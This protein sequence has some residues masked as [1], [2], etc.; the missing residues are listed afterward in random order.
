MELERV[1]L[2]VAYCL[3]EISYC[4]GM[5]FIASVTI[6]VMESEESGFFVFMHLLLNKDVK[7]LFLPV[8]LH[9]NLHRAYQSFT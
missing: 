3:P 9:H 8:S 7:N 4:Q 5:N 6:A 1:L 2:A